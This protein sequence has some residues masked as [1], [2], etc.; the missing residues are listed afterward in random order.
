MK[1]IFFLALIILLLF[2]QRTQA[3]GYYGVLFLPIE[4]KTYPELLRFSEAVRLQKTD[5]IRPEI[6]IWLEELKQAGSRIVLPE[7]SNSVQ[8]LLFETNFELQQYDTNWHSNPGKLAERLRKICTRKKYSESEIS[9]LLWCKI[10]HLNILYKHIWFVYPLC[11]FEDEFF[12]KVFPTNDTNRSIFLDSVHY[13]PV[14][15]KYANDSFLFQHL[16]S[17]Y[18]LNFITF[19]NLWDSTFINQKKHYFDFEQDFPEAINAVR[20]KTIKELFRKTETGEYLL[21]YIQYSRGS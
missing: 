14:D 5:L 11:G 17:Y 12:N 9:T 16:N 3:I 7:D 4:A 19:L 18:S 13:C 6:C 8:G 20:L 21:F 10:S 15:A 2:P 1:G